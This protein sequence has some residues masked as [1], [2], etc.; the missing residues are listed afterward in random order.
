MTNAL[1]TSTAPP[2]P[3]PSASTDEGKGGD[4]QQRNGF[5]TVVIEDSFLQWNGERLTLPRRP[6][7]ED[8]SS[9]FAVIQHLKEHGYRTRSDFAPGDTTVLVY[10]LVDPD[11]PDRVIRQDTPGK[12]RYRGTTDE[13]GNLVCVQADPNLKVV[14]LV[15]EDSFL[16]VSGARISGATVGTFFASIWLTSGPGLLQRMLRLKRKLPNCTSNR[17]RCLT[18]SCSFLADLD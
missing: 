5:H 9:Y 2:P 4:Q 11:H 6:F 10:G 17:L 12:L 1:P 3:E 7:R 15:I 14:S 8:G 13:D 16:N 18:P